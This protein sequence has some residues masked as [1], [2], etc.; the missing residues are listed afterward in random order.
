MTEIFCLVSAST[1]KVLRAHKGDL[2]VQK[3][4]VY[5]GESDLGGDLDKVVD[6]PS[7][8]CQLPKAERCAVHIIR[9][10]TDDDIRKFQW[11]REKE[12]KAFDLCLQRI[13]ARNLPMRLVAGE[14][15]FN[16]K[17]RWC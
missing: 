1:G 5:L 15:F 10:A 14:R 12:G 8:V 4:D 17:Q 7:D 2:D 13:K 6:I 16:E 9:R 11:L 3:G